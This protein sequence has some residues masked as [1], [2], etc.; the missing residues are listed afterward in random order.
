MYA[1][2]DGST[3]SLVQKKAT[4]FPGCCFPLAIFALAPF[5][6]SMRQNLNLP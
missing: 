1:Y 4:T 5:Q 6:N 3:Q 2:K